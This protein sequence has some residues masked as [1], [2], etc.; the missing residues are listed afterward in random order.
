MWPP[1]V[2]L[3][4]NCFLYAYHRDHFLSIIS[5]SIPAVN[6]G[7]PP[8]ISQFKWH[9]TVHAP[10]RPLSAADINDVLHISNCDFIIRKRRNVLMNWTIMSWRCSRYSDAQKLKNNKQQHNH[11]PFYQYAINIQEFF[12]ILNSHSCRSESKHDL[13]KRMQI[14]I[15]L[16]RYFK[17]F[18]YGS[19]RMVNISCNNTH[20]L[21]IQKLAKAHVLW[22]SFYKCVYTHLYD[23]SDA[24]VYLRVYDRIAYASTVIS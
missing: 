17:I 19:L 4:K 9:L 23:C 14:K 7:I 2:R 20:S 16:Y 3:Q 22:H 18:S 11:E 5:S 13:V 24:N 10:Y 6:I 15:I 12:W 21:I 8:S 1:V